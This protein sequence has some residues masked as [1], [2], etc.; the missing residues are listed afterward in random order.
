MLEIKLF[1]SL[2]G[3]K[4]TK[5]IFIQNVPWFVKNFMRGH[6]KEG[7]SVVCSKSECF[8]QVVYLK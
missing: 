5:L 2:W 7:D 6:Y 3:F 8:K 4:I 1:Y